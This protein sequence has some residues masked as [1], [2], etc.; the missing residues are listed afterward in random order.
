M[1]HAP[2]G[3][4]KTVQSSGGL[5]VKDFVEKAIKNEKPSERMGTKFVIKVFEEFDFCAD[6]FGD[7]SDLS[8]DED[9]ID[10]LLLDGLS[11][12]HDGGNK[13]RTLGPVTKYLRRR[14]P[15]DKLNFY[16]LLH[17]ILEGPSLAHDTARK[18]QVA[19]LE[20]IERTFLSK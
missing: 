5:F 11:K 2:G 4:I 15:L 1:A 10:Q 14:E 8:E 6:V 20:T 16:G 7:L 18:L 9:S 17:G 12:A 13:V 3:L 19:T